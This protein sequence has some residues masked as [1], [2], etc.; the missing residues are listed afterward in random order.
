MGRWVWG[1]LEPV[2]YR[3]Y[4]T[5]LWQP[6]E[7]IKENRRLLIPSD[8]EPGVYFLKMGFFNT[9]TGEVFIVDRRDFSGRV[10]LL[11]LAV[12]RNAYNNY[13]EKR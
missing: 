9:A 1:S 5:N 7:W 10:C 6:G 8:L 4:P 2:C 13:E 11:R 3:I 12:G